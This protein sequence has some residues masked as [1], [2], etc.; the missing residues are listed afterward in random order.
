MIPKN[1]AEKL[2]YQGFN[3]ELIENE[4]LQYLKQDSIF[5]Y[6]WCVAY[7]DVRCQSC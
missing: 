7:F 5:Q 6:R 1:G 2:R 3:S 4:K